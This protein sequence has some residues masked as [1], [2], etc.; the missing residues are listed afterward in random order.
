VQGSASEFDDQLRR[1]NDN[2]SE[3]D[4]IAPGLNL[5]IIRPAQW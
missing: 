4:A 2:F 5:I 3:G 1:A